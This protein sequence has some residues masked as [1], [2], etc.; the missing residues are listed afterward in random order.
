MLTGLALVAEDVFKGGW[1][2]VRYLQSWAILAKLLLLIAA[3]A[4]PALLVP[5]LWCALIIG[6]V[7]SHAPGAVRQFPLWGEPGPCATPSDR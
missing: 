6:S 7:I 1:D 2:Y 3:M 4:W 5:A